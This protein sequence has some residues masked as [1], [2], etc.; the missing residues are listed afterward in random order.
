MKLKAQHIIR[1]PEIHIGHNVNTYS[2]ITRLIQ[3]H[4]ST[5]SNESFKVTGI[6]KSNGAV[7][8]YSIARARGFFN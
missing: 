5:W 3:G 2:K 7:F 1:Y 8:Y 4:V 6:T